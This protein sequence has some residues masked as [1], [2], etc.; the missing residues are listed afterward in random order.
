VKKHVAKRVPYRKERDQKWHPSVRIEATH[1]KSIQL[2]IRLG[3][4]NDA[5][6][7]TIR[8]AYIAAGVINPRR[9]DAPPEPRA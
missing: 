6:H 2:L 3:H 5:Y 7:M 9:T 1:P 4:I 8:E